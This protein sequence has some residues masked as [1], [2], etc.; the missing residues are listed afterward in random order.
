MIIYHGNTSESFTLCQHAL[1]RVIYRYCVNYMLERLNLVEDENPNKNGKTATP[2][3]PVD[4]QRTRARA[5]RLTVVLLKP[6]GTTGRE[7]EGQWKHTLGCWDPSWD[8]NCVPSTVHTTHFIPASIDSSR[9]TWVWAVIICST[10]QAR[11]VASP[12]QSCL[13]CC[14]PIDV[15]SNLSYCKR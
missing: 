13:D 6:S 9:E 2:F 1:C 5:G 3:Y 8:W 14:C 7:E 4:E 12:H 10:R 11:V 15:M